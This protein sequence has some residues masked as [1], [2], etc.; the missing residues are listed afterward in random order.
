MT[1]R[2]V[3]FVWTLVLLAAWVAYAPG[4]AGG[5]VFDDFINLPALGETGP[6]LDAATF[7]RYITSG[8][9]DP[10]GRPIALLSFLIDARNWPADPAPFLLTN[11]LIHLLNGT[12]LW[13]LLRQLGKAIATPA[14]AESAAIVGAGIWVLHPLLVSTTLYIVQREAMLPAT[15]TL[16]GLLGWVRGRMLAVEN[17]KRGALWMLAAMGSCTLLAFLSKA[18]GA[19]LPLFALVLDTTVLRALRVGEVPRVRF[20]RRALTMAPAGA[21]ALYLLLPLLHAYSPIPGRQWTLAERLMTQPRVL[22]DYVQL[23]AVPRALSTGVYND[24]YVASRGLLDPPG[25]L[26]AILIVSGAIVGA[27]LARKRVPA[28]SAAVLFFFVGHVIEGSTIALEL[29]FEHRNYLP[30]MLAFWPL[31]LAI[32]RWRTGP[33]LRCGTA[34]FLLVLCGVVTWQRAELWGDQPRMA[35][36]WAARSPDSSRAQA[37]AAMFEMS[38]GHVDI[39]LAR[40]VPLWRERPADL[41]L[42]LNAAA[43]YCTR[44]ALPPEAARNVATALRG[45]TEG[46]E[47]LHH[48]LLR[49]LALSA[50]GNCKGLDDATIRSFLDAAWQNPRFRDTPGRRQDL[51]SLQGRLALH[52]G[53]PAEAARLFEQAMLEDPSPQS[54]GMQATLLASAGEYTRAL[55][56]LD[57]YKTL[58]HRVPDAWGMVRLHDRVLVRQGYWEKRI[59][60]LRRALV[61]ELA[62]TESTPTR[63]TD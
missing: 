20:I 28:L 32:S 26:I 36:L 30:A 52:H 59:A 53:D 13:R 45:A 58:P 38:D 22:L 18:N 60:G 50:Q 10:V 17:P 35:K 49:A 15:F 24:A 25:T 55:H 37:T 2:S 4:L 8:T 63:N 33:A 40:L 56:L 7:W 61:A 9:A 29:F 51:Y 27:L 23:L 41:Q 31:G 6:V 5:F 1:Q 54:A 48:W 42:A 12:L 14:Q 11:V 47:L 46:D 43:A 39:A 57:K 19:L 34:A 21:V 62:K 3:L 16:L 44:G